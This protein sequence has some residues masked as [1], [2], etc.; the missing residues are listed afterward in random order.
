MEIKQNTRLAQENRQLFVWTSRRF[1]NIWGS[2]LIEETTC[3]VQFKLKPASTNRG[4]HT[5]RNTRRHQERLKQSF[6]TSYSRPIVMYACETWST[7]KE[8]KTSNIWETNFK[9]DIVWSH[10]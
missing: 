5:M 10:A 9:G 2:I 4:H 7:S 1:L 6:N 3:T 8:T